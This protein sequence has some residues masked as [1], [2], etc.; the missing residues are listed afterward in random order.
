MGKIEMRKLWLR[1]LVALVVLTLGIWVATRWKVWFYNPAEPPYEVVEAPSRVLLTFGNEGELSRYVSWM[2]G[3]EV[4]ASAC[5]LLVEHADVLPQDVALTDAEALPQDAD[6]IKNDTL[7]IEAIGEVFESRSG[8]AAY[9]RA[10]LKALQPDC[11]YSYAVEA[12]G[13]R[14]PWYS[15]RT[16]DPASQAFSFLYMGDVQDSIGGIANQL[17]RKAVQRHP[18][19][20][21]VA[22]GGDLTERPMDKY[23]AETFRTLDSVCTTL[24]VLNVTGN[25]DYLKYLIRRCERR[26]ALT[27]PYFLLGMAERQDQNHLFHFAYHGTHFYMLDSDRGVGFLWQQRQ[28]LEQELALSPEARHRIALLHHP[29]YSVKRKNNNLEVRWMFNGL[30]REAGVELVLQG[31]EHAY[32]HCTSSD[33]PLQGSDCTQP[34]L[35][36]VSHCSPKN[37]RIHPIQRFWPVHNDSRYYQVVNVDAEAV[38]LRAYDA[39][40]QALLDSVRIANKR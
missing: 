32:T 29:L 40:T 11:A 23:W 39:C 19:V 12:N 25:H 17:L 4:D 3:T 8:H 14:S 30:L 24:P 38:T 34:P 13:E 22:F 37:Y 20:E 15:F 28:W 9:Y 27:F 31:H 16:S 1:A 33:E 10:H 6:L 18:E 26:F 7:R 36:V 2:A 21:F 5:L 35:Y